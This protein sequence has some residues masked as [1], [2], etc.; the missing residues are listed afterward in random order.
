ML[1]WLAG[2]EDISKLTGIPKILVVGLI[3]KLVKISSPTNKKLKRI[4]IYRRL[5]LERELMKITIL[6]PL[7]ISQ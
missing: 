4:S 3:S 1:C 2:I 6:Q 7:I 5:G